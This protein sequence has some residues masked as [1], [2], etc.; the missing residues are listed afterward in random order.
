MTSVMTPSTR[1][2]LCQRPVFVLY[3][4]CRHRLNRVRRAAAYAAGTLSA[5]QAQE[6]IEDCE[7]D[8]Q[9]FALMTLAADHVMDM[10][11]E[12]YGDKAVLLKPYLRDAC[13][14]VASKWDMSSDDYWHPRDWA[15]STAVRAARQDGIELNCDADDEL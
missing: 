15:L 2:T 13:G 3:W 12:T 5:S 7:L 4:R 11:I 1:R 9:S 6:I 14:Y 8:A 10:A